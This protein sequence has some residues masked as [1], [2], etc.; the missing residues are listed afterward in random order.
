M[1][2]LAFLLLIGG[3]LIADG[4]HYHIPK[5][6]IYGPIAFSVFVEAMNLWAG[7]RTARRR[8]RA[9]GVDTS[10]EAF[11]EAEIASAAGAGAPGPQG[12]QWAAVTY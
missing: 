4:L 10:A 5:G 7:A 3:S 9:A 12:G 1:L 6:Y 8:A 11:L 2:A